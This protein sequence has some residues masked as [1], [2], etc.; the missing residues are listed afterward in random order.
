MAN[1]GFLLLTVEDLIMDKKAIIE[2]LKEVKTLL[3]AARNAKN[4]I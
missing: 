3:W 1:I 2:K 4:Q